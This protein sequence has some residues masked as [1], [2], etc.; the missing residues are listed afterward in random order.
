MLEMIKRHIEAFNEDDWEAYKAGYADDAEFIEMPTQQH[1]RGPAEI[2]KLLQ[3][4]KLAFPDL[5]GTIVNGAASGDKL[6]I[7]VN[8]E[9][10]HTGPLDGPFGTIE[11]TGKTGKVSAAIIFT[12]KG[13][14]I[15]TTHHYFD[16]MTVLLQTGAAPTTGVA[17]E[18]QP[19]V[20]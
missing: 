6:F 15:A 16:V 8:W 19:A 2:A 5:R 18:G 12:M 9:G 20:H 3:R 7:E 13:E 14:K 10:T 1:A 11:P 17:A 4:W